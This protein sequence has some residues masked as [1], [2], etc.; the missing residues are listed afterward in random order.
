M[1]TEYGEAELFEVLGSSRRREIIRAL[2]GEDDSLMRAGTLAD[3]VA[4]REAEAREPGEDPPPNVRNSIYNTIV[5]NHLPRLA[6]FDVVE[7]D[8]ETKHAEPGPNFRVTHNV[9]EVAVTEL[10]TAGSGGAS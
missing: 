6:G 3:H 7:F 5:Q 4:K 2:A 10:Q 8:E 1:T 9:L